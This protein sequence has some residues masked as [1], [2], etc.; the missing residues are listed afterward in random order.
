M[1]GPAD[2]VLTGAR[3]RTGVPGRPPVEAL[4]VAVRDGRIAAVGSLE[5]MRGLAGPGTE[6]I[7]V[8]G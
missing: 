7:E 8:P 3:A 2:L 6:V 5:E 1:S 4:D